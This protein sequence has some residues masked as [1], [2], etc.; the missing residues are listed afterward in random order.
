MAAP[1]SPREMMLAVITNMKEKTGRTLE[2]WVTFVRKNGPATR[3]EQ[4][5]WLKG[6]HGVG[7]VTASI[8]VGEVEEEGSSTEYE[9]TDALLDGMYSGPYAPLRTVYEDL[10]N[11]VESFGE[12]VRVSICKTYVG[13]SRRRQF[14]I[15]KPAGRNR[16]DVGLALPEDTDTTGRLEKAGSSMGSDRMTRRVPVHSQKEVDAE[17]KKWL[18]EAYELAG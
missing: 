12:D 15:L 8:I 7:H 4:M 3:K 10:M 17:V 13:L 16:V 14:A 5:A 6:E 9:N 18:R 2:E 11:M 1:K